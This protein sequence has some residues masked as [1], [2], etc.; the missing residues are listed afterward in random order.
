MTP[1]PAAGDILGIEDCTKATTSRDEPATER[2]PH[3]LI[4]AKPVPGS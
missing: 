3:L 4:N 1:A 2:A